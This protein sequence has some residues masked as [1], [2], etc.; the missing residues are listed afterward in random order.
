MAKKFTYKGK[1]IEELQK[2]ELKEFANLLPARQRRSLLRG[3]SEPKKILLEKIK[4][5][6]TKKSIKT[7]VRDMIV[8]PEMVDA[9][10]AVYDS[11][12]H[13]RSRNP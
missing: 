6:K 9:T 3:L 12:L 2:L 1:T 13:L 11:I 7:H 5:Y 8:I 4:K 10:L